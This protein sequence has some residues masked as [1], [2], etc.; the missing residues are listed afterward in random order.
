MLDDDGPIFPQKKDGGNLSSVKHLAHAE[1]INVF[2]QQCWPTV[3][4]RVAG[5]LV[6]PEF[7]RVYSCTSGLQ[8]NTIQYLFFNFS[9]LNFYNL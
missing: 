4:E 3:I 7:Q 2:V 9:K 6:V 5:P 1:R 8:Y